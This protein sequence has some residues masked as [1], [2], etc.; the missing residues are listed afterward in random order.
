[1]AQIK[2]T[3]DEWREKYQPVK[4][5]LVKDAPHDGAFFETYGQEQEFVQEIAHNSPHK[6][7]TI[8]TGQ[9]CGDTI[10]EGY[11]LVN[12]LGYL[13][14][15][16]PFAEDESFEIYLEACE[17]YGVGADEQKLFEKFAEEVEYMDDEDDKEYINETLKEYRESK[18]D[19]QELFVAVKNRMNDFDSDWNEYVNRNKK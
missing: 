13:I 5:H 16:N 11:H 4:N 3:Y 1:M 9:E 10:V 19:F 14:T 12:R 15:Q 7:W 2:I 6:V 18:I 17:D 8:L